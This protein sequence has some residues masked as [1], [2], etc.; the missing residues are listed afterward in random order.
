[1]VIVV[2]GV[3]DDVFE[4]NPLLKLAGQ[5]VAAAIPVLNGVNASA[6]TL[7]FVGSVDLR[8]VEL[9]DSA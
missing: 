9:L 4:L 8:T 5:T 6:F 7:P 2:V 3:L 1:M